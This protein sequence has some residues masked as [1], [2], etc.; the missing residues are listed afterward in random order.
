MIV[1]FLIKGIEFN[2]LSRMKE[3]IFFLLGVL[4]VGI[5]GGIFLVCSICKDIFGLELNEIVVLYW[6]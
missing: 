6:E 1:E 4:L 2:I 5:V 3:I